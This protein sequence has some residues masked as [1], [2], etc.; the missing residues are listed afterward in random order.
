MPD[1]D[2]GAQAWELSFE[3][4]RR[5]R[6]HM[7]ALQER[8]QLSPM[9]LHA[10]RALTPGEPMPVGQ[11]ARCIYC[12]PP[13]IVKVVGRLEGRGFIVRTSDPSDARVR[14]V[15]LTAEGERMNAQV[16][17]QFAAIPEHIAALSAADQRRLRDLLQ[18]M[19]SKPAAAPDDAEIA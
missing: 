15:Q 9:D 16:V 1:I 7:R 11:L 18:R 19:L 2:P 5:H 13:N 12:E 6:A 3:L 10:L 14:R 8:F 17:E 4:F